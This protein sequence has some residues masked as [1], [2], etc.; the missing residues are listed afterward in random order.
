MPSKNVVRNY[1]ENGYYH[2]FNRGVE[3]RRIFENAGDYSEFIRYLKI[4]L[5]NPEDLRRDEPLLK[6]NLVKGNLFGKLE[7]IAYCLM[8]T[9]FRFL[10]KQTEKDAVTKFMRQLGTAYTMY[11]NRKYE[12]VGPLFQGKF[13]AAKVDSPDQLLY[14]SRYIHQN[15]LS[16]GI[17]LNDYEWSSFQNYTQN[18]HTPWIKTQQI[19][20]HFNNSKEGVSYA[21]FVEEDQQETEII[22]NITL[23]F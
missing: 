11:F 6:L 13:R 3:K 18:R 22:A 12:R 9:H 14:L 17:S 2:I 20:E 8:P 23:D 5:E 21:N 16:R 1:T 10:V 4:Y 15:P 19:L 7:L